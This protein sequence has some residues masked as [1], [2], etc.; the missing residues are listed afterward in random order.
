[1]NSVLIVS[2]AND[3]HA[4]FLRDKLEEKGID[5]FLFL[6]DK[7]PYKA[8]ITI[9]QDYK[10]VEYNCREEKIDARWSIWNRR[11]FPPEFPA[12]FPSNLEEMV[13]EEAKR[14]IHGLMNVHDGLVV[15]RPYENHAANNKIE[16]LRRARKLGFIV[17][18]TIVTN[19][20]KAAID[21]YKKHDN[22]IIFK[23]Q[24]LPIIKD[25]ET[26]STI[27]TSRVLEE[28]MQNNE[29]I[30]NSSCLFQ[31]RIEKDYETRLTVVGD[32]LFPVAIHSQDSELSKDDFRRYDF[33]KVK[34]E[35][36]EIPEDIRI[37]TKRLVRSYGL[38]YAAL[39]IIKTPDDKYVFLEI[40][41]NGQY[42]WTEEL[43]GAKITDALAEYLAEGKNDR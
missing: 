34:Y 23:M 7:Y 20:H 4:E 9:C 6:T 26:Y 32:R 10:L 11:V 37:K 35:Q 30:N 5:S 22:D 19:D 38:H 27:M 16:Q 31:E 24:K 8:M 21:F 39:D 41:P 40:N 15:N 2:G 29:R 13:R 33:E 42:L 43:S 25:D 1:M 14:T 17:P 36:V 12:G 28:H 18:D 3:K